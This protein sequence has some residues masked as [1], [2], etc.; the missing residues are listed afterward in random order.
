MAKPLSEA[1]IVHRL[2]NIETLSIN[3]FK[4]LLLSLQRRP[5]AT[6]ETIVEKMVSH[7]ENGTDRRT[8]KQISALLKDTFKENPPMAKTVYAQR[9]LSSIKKENLN[10]DVLIFRIEILNALL[11]YNPE[12]AKKEGLADQFIDLGLEHR[13][14]I[15]AHC[16]AALKMVFA[17]ND[18]EIT[19]VLIEK[20]TQLYDEAQ[21]HHF[22]QSFPDASDPSKR[23]IKNRDFSK[24][25]LEM[26]ERA[27]AISP[28][29][30]SP[31]CK[32]APREASVASPL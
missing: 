24:E 19:P 10:E 26:A 16:F 5:K 20:L 29:P 31:A 25:I 4:S 3:D 15:R 2:Q 28:S 18:A 8:L 9:M 6:P 23:L 21:K 17:V 13:G 11:F 1:E 12:S 32:I 7:I 30:E 22:Q 14:D 27:A